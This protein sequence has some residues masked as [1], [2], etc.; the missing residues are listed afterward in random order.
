MDDPKDESPFY[1]NTE[2]DNDQHSARRK[3]WLKRQLDCEGNGCL[4]MVFGFG[5]WYLVMMIGCLIFGVVG[6]LVIEGCNMIVPEELRYD[7]EPGEFDPW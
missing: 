3:G 2:S 1:I 7:P 4:L 6:V 5:S